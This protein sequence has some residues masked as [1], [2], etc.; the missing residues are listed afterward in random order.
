MVHVWRGGGC[1]DECIEWSIRVHPIGRVSEAIEGVNKIKI[2]NRMS[3]QVCG[4]RR[5]LDAH[6]GGISR[7]LFVLDLVEIVLV[8]LA[9]EGCKVGVLEHSRQ[10]YLCEFGHIFDDE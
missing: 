1:V 5:R 6:L 3:D 10:Y 4:A 8:E 2:N 7:G 9:D